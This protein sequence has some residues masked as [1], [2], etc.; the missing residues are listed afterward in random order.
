MV[1]AGCARPSFGLYCARLAGMPED[2]L[3]R[4]QQDYLSHPGPLK[5]LFFLLI[6]FGADH[7]WRFSYYT[8]RQDPG[9][10]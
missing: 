2:L 9:A 10:D 4:A 1:C 6:L 8:A 7:V 5:S 3:Q